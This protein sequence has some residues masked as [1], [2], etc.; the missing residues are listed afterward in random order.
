MRRHIALTAGDGGERI[1]RKCLSL[2]KKEELVCLLQRAVDLQDDFITLCESDHNPQVVD[3][4]SK[5]IGKKTAFESVL[6]A[7]RGDRVYLNIEAGI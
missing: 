1:M 5:A 2:T 6:C 7:L 3:M 4:V